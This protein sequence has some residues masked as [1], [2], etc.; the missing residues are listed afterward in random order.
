MSSDS[1][2]ETPTP[3]RVGF[4]GM[5]LA[6]TGFAVLLTV[7]QAVGG[8]ESADPRG[9]ERLAARE[10]IEEAQTGLVASLG[11]NDEAKSEALF[12]KTAKALAQKKPSKSS[13]VVPGSPTQLKMASQEA[14]AAAPAEAPAE[15]KKEGEASPETPAN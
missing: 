13:Q 3:K 7:L 6:F 11:L 5:L 1:T 15:E 12:Q 8:G 4:F 9:E 2:T 14:A 10:A